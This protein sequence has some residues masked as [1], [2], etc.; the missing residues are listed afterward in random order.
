LK[1]LICEIEQKPELE[2]KPEPWKKRAPEPHL[3]KPR[4]LEPAL[5]H[6]YNGPA[7]LVMLKG[8]ICP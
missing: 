5:C 1:I 2:L 7:A 8:T 4:A 3:Q 6:F